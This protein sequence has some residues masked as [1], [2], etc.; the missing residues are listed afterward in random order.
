M[1]NRIQNAFDGINAEEKLKQSTSSFLHSKVYAKK[2]AGFAR[3]AAAFAAVAILFAAGFAG[4]NTY[5]SEAGVVD[6]DVNPSIAMGFNDFG[7]VIS[8]HAYNDEGSAVLENV[9]IRH[10][11]Y[12][13]AL[14]ILIAEMTE[15]GYVKDRGMVTATLQTQNSQ[16]EPEMLN[17]MKTCIDAALPQENSE[18]IEKE[19]YAV[20]SATKE[21]ALEENLTP[22]KYIAIVELQEV[23]PTATF[24]TCRNSS[25][26]EIKGQMHKKMN[27][28]GKGKNSSDTVSEPAESEKE[29]EEAPSATSE[30]SSSETESRKG[31]GM[32]DGSGGMGNGNGAGN[33]N[34]MGNGKGAGNG[35]GMGNGGKGK[36]GG[37]G[38]RN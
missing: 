11:S 18:A 15:A 30:V 27:G 20:D 19:V 8:T 37:R 17:A 33:G 5:Y 6:I 34:G 21:E 28:K 35:K 2:R 32:G 23:D 29:T 24:E 3:Y 10:K 12:T 22:A 26:G 7:R 36:H 16:S 14:E 1:N 38:N 13:E 31:S 4:Y 9:D 25:I